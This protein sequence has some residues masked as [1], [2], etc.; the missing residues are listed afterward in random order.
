MIS[1]ACECAAGYVNQY[2]NNVVL[3]GN[4]I[5]AIGIIVQVI[6]GI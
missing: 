1:V 4:D 3:H 6:S 5:T 2:Q